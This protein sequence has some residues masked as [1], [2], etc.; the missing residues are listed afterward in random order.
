MGSDRDN[1]FHSWNMSTFPIGKGQFAA[2]WRLIPVAPKQHLEH[3]KAWPRVR[4]GRRHP[5]PLPWNAG[6]VFGVRGTES[7]KRHGLQLLF[8]AALTKLT[9]LEASEGQPLV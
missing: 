1:S 4:L 7:S 2:S 3:P 9:L 6:E 5:L 8:P